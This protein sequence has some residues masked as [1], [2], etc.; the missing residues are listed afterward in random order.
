MIDSVQ[1]RAAGKQF[2]RSSLVRVSRRHARGAR[3]SLMRYAGPCADGVAHPKSPNENGSAFDG[4]H[5]RPFGSTGWASRVVRDRAHFSHGHATRIA[6]IASTVNGRCVSSG[7]V[8]P[9]FT[10][11]STSC[12]VVMPTGMD[13]HSSGSS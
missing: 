6:D 4:S 2:E 8:A 5:L 11:T 10:T 12:W 9:Y 1:P 7:K 13:V 3:G